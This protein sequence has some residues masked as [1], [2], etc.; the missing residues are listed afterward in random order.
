MNRRLASALAAAAL[1]VAVGAPTAIARDP[2]TRTFDRLD[3]STLSKI[4]KTLLKE[5]LG[6][7]NRKVNVILQLAAKPVALRA[8]DAL[9]LG[10]TLTKTEK[11]TIRKSVLRTQ[12]ALKARITAAGG[13]VQKQYAD[14]YNG[15]K[16]RVSTK[17][18]AR[19]ARLPGI[20]AVK[21]IPKVRPT[22][23]NAVPFTGVPA[24]W[25]DYG[26]TGAGVK[27][28][29]IDTGIDYTHADF[30]GVGTPEAFAA[31][32][33]TI[34][35]PGTFPT[36]KV[37]GG[38]DFV[39]D[40]YNADD[41]NHNVPVPDPDPIDCAIGQH[42]THVAGIAAGDGVKA[43]GSTY[44]GP[45]GRTTDFSGFKVGPGVA[46]QASLYA[47]RVFGCEGSSEILVD[48]I[49]AAV[50]AG[51]DVINMSLGSDLGEADA[52]DAVAA[53]NAAKAGI[54]VVISAGNAGP[55]PYIIGAPGTATRAITVAAQD[56]TATVPLATVVLPNEED[57][58]GIDMNGVS[59]PV[60]GELVVLKNDDDSISLGCDADAYSGT[61]V[62]GKIVAIKR[63]DCAFVDKGGAA[64][65][66]GAAG[67]IVINR[68][69]VAPDE[70]PVFI[71][72]NPDLFDIP[73]VGLANAS[74]TA[75]LDSEGDSVDLVSNGT[76]ANP[77]FTESADF[78]SMGP[79]HTDSLM[80][81]DVSAPGVNILSALAGSGSDATQFS[82]T[83]MAA[84]YTSGVAA[85]VVQAHPTWSAARI[86]AAIVNTAIPA[87][88]SGYDPM[89]AGSGGIRPHRAVSTVG[90]ATVA[91]GTSSLSFGYHSN[92]GPITETK[93][94]TLTNTS[95][96][97]ITYDLSASFVGGAQ[98]A[99]ISFSP[100]TVRVPSHSHRNVAVTIKLSAADV[101]ALPN[102]AD[103]PDGLAM[104]ALRGVVIVN[105]RGSA[106]GR[107]NLRVP[108]LLVPRGESD[109]RPSGAL[110]GVTVD[111][112][113]SSASIKIKNFGLHAGIADVYAWGEY[114]A[115][116]GQT[117]TD[118]R[119]TG[120]QSIPG[121]EA[122]LD[123]SDKLIVFAVN[124]WRPWSTASDLDLE[125][126]V[127]TNGD[128]ETDFIV[129]GIDLGL[130]FT[131]FPTGETGVITVDPEFN[132]IDGW[133]GTAPINGSTYLLP[134]TASDLGLADGSGSFDYDTHA[135][136]VVTEFGAGFEDAAS[137]VG[138]FD[139]FDPAV[140]QGEYISLTRDQS[141]TLRLK[142][143][144]TAYILNPAK[145][146]MVVS[147]DDA[148]GRAQANL[149][150]I[151]SIPTR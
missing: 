122:G 105:P 98:G 129:V 17:D 55:A 51:V 99:A 37:V 102:A 79:R 49:D 88:V 106:A 146:W 73:M 30:G 75:I 39:G 53:D 136:P 24:T 141:V 133:S 10:R 11:T 45:Y 111:G 16:V 60:S 120:A 150:P 5:V 22:L 115:D 121:P 2:A 145:G 87:D 25:G 3:T 117:K 103:F 110:S 74:Q 34:I 35:E 23:V 48:A 46:P 12:N 31:N 61:D 90:L 59:L 80:K 52:P 81:P 147:H 40:D 116:D 138:H 69:D 41:E 64:D 126:E 33:P 1:L 128:G 101:K 67:L 139:P 94:L 7:G 131:G 96:T 8:A 124:M 112:D 91:G 42:G 50:A 84:P 36:A 28:A 104:N 15:I 43:D 130:V 63:G 83:S 18:L 27:I 140:S 135:Y 54:A 108:F 107:Y 57:Q 113:T 68:D 76:E 65:A 38:T 82:G 14:A 132:I 66:A 125:V 142:T 32:D 58:N 71:G 100:K 114:D 123:P 44:T 70:L 127:D 143:H 109:I 21:A 89:L 72:F 9:S 148:D 6:G 151:W 56:T 144:R 119:A 78:T 93:V 134:T 149:V 47:Y 85:L 95:G 29:I 137:G 92:D 97:A 118:I 19:L 77:T 4:D 86:K 20:V 62:E 26:Y 13:K